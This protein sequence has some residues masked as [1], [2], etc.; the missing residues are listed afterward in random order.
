MILST[1]HTIPGK[2][3]VK[4]FGLAKGNTIR[5]RHA[6]QDIMAGLKNLVGGEIHEYTKLMAESR[7][8]AM[9]RMM[10]DAKRMGANAIVGVL[11][12][13]S[14]IMN[15]AAELLAYGTAVWVEDE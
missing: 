13:T 12:S 1:T 5:A 10:D 3:I 11:Y 6:G 14:E 4:V 9:D 15:G 8:Q 7:E 2:R